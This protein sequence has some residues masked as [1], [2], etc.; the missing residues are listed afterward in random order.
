MIVMSLFSIRIS[1]VSAA[2]GA[3]NVLAAAG[4]VRLRQSV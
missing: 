2:S 1:H 3:P 4:F